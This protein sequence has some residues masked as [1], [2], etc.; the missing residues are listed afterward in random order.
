MED[1]ADVQY[2]GTKVGV[3]SRFFGNISVAGIKAEDVIKV[4]DM[5]KIYDKQ[6][7]V[8]VEQEAVPAEE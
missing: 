5:V 8:V 4:G 3:V 2:E 7:N 1:G 6:G